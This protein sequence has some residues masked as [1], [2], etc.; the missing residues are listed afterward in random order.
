[1]GTTKHVQH[2][3]ANLSIDTS[4]GAFVHLLFVHGHSQGSDSS[5][6]GELDAFLD[7]VGDRVIEGVAKLMLCS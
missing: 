2:E 4:C 1:M 6:A 5:S 7:R 3:P